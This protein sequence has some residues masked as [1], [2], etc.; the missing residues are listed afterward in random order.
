MQTVVATVTLRLVTPHTLTAWTRKHLARLVERAATTAPLIH[1]SDVVRILPAYDVWDLWPVRELDGA[2]SLTA[3]GELWIALSAPA[4][5]APD[6]RHDVTRLRLLA[7]RDGRWTHMGPVFP[8]GASPGSREWAGSTVHRDGSVTVFYTAA[9]R[10]GEERRTFVQRIAQATGRLVIEGTRIE[11]TDWS[12]HRESVQADGVVY[13]RAEEE[14]GEPG[15]I[16]AFRDPFFFRDPAS[17]RDYLL[18]TG[19]LASAETNF[20]GAIGIAE[21]GDDRWSRWSLLPPLL[22]AHGVNNELERPHVVVR[23]G[24]YYLLFSTQR[25]TFHPDVTGPTGLYGFVGPSLLGPYEAINE[26]GLVL[27]NP[28]EEP[29]QAYSWLV[30]NDLRVVSF[31]D[32]HSLRGRRP[33]DLA[34]ER[35]ARS[36]FGG[37]IA[38]V[39]QLAFDGTRAW[40]EGIAGEL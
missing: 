4:T 26:S 21:A 12:H 14:Y 7:K 15:F 29:F 22:H 5:G 34:S 31:V 38:P 19:S 13:L 1:A 23:E 9:G 40:I 32:F 20:N 11:L 28:P 18:F 2:V 6:A 30:L 10:R 36:A 25:R 39:L 33:G 27:Q 24:R 37:T 3:D 16:K 8:D 17:D 35:E